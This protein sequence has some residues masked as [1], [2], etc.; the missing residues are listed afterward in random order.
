MKLE[1][2][3]FCGAPA[4]LSRFTSKSQTLIPVEI[5]Q[6]QC[7]N[8]NDCKVTFDI[9]HIN[10]AVAVEAWNRRANQQIKKAP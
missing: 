8:D 9:Q 4:K 1:P 7:D 3:P 6:I 2:C 10:E 5:T